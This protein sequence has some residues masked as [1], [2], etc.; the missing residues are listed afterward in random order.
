MSEPKSEAQLCPA[1]ITID[2]TPEQAQLLEPHF[3]W[4][5]EEFVKNRPG[6][7]VGQ[8]IRLRESGRFYMEIGFLSNEKAALFQKAVAAL[9]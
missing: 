6:M 1:H 9:S 3:D 4:A 2:L 5:S 8:V 7:L